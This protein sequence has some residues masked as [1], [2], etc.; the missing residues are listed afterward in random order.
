MS[1]A[2][3][4]CPEC[5]EY[6]GSLGGDSCIHC[7]WMAPCECDTETIEITDEMVQVALLAEEEAYFSYDATKDYGALS[8]DKM[9]QHLMRAALEAALSHKTT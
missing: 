6:L 8:H 1:G 9:R 4:Y 2:Y 7:K 5:S 3:L